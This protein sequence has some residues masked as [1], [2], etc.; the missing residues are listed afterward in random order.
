[1]SLL[2]AL[3]AVTATC[4]P[5]PALAEAGPQRVRDYIA[6]I[7]ARDQ[8][9]TGRFIKAGAV[10]S[11]PVVAAEPLAEVITRLLEAPNADRLDVVEATPRGAA[12]YLRTFTAG[13]RSGRALVELD[14][15]CVTRFTLE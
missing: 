10:Y 3:L 13:G 15:G 5:D 6:A 2:L 4:T 9:A 1:M 14:G 11:S 12:V 8:A 7:N